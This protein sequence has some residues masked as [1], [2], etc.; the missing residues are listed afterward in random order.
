[1]PMPKLKAQLETVCAERGWDARLAQSAV[2]GG[3]AKRLIKI[4][5][6]AGKG[7][8]VRFA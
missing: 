4:D 1:M 3:V 6:K 7:G 2:Y 8:I 5:R